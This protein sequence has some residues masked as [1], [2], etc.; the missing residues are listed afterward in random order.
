[1]TNLY[2]VSATTCEPGLNFRHTPRLALHR[3]LDGE[4]IDQIQFEAEMSGLNELLRR[5]RAA[6]KTVFSPGV[7][8]DTK[9]A[10]EQKA[11]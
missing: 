11:S 3:F 2:I 9:I 8:R 5:A 4:D 1:L 10:F 7:S 6:L